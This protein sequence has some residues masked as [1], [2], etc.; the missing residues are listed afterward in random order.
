MD[1]DQASFEEAAL[2]VARPGS[3][4]VGAAISPD[5]RYGV[6]VAIL[7]SRS[8]YPMEDLF[9]RIDGRWTSIGGGGGAALSW[10]AFGDAPGILRYA[11]PAPA[12]ARAALISYEGTVHRVAVHRG[13]FF[14]VSW[15][16]RF[17]EEPILLG[18]E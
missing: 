3:V 2:S 8:D 17:T 13:W 5:G 6:A 15:N 9:E 10:T 1:D 12:D 14:F 4:L 11:E 18:F 7:P 16:T